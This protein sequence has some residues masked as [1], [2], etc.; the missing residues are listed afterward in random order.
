MMKFWLFLVGLGLSASG[1]SAQRLATLRLD[2][3]RAGSGSFP[4]STSLDELTLLPDSVLHLVEVQGRRRSI[5]PSQIEQGEVRRLHW[6]VEDGAGK[7]RKRTY[8]LVQGAHAAT[9]ATMQAVQ[10]GGALL[11]RAKDRELLQY[12]YKTAYPPAGV[13]TAYKR[14]GFIHPLWSPR[15]QELTRIQPP[16]H[17]HHY[18]IWNP[19]THVLFEGDTVDF[20]NIRN[21]T[22]TVRFASLAA[23]ASGPV[24]SGYQVVQEH[25][26]YRKKG[27]EKVALNELQSVRVYQPSDQGYY[28]ADITISLSCASASPVR[29]L[30][31]RYGGLSWRATEKWNRDNSEILT[32]A[33]RSRKEADGSA[34][35][36]CLAQ[37]KLEPDS[38]GIILMSHPT[39]YNHPEPLRVWPETQNKRGDVFINFSPTK[40]RDWLLQPG[41]T[42]TLRYRLLVY[43]GRRTRE[44]A[45]SNWRNFGSPP[46]VSVRLK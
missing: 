18:G 35:R 43:S 33:G 21:R 44:Q 10:Q 8:E 23:A 2:L 46:R 12:N 42:Y 19:W 38:A 1:A 11:I 4:V 22:G 41:R 15:G 5:V 45:E 6:L 24:F 36:W 20:W 34:A 40:D 39:N 30:K 31:Y 16:D 32:S 27:Q 9:A 26:A 17:Y 28:I 7:P 29:L 25:V 37:G 3:P 13:D 14:S